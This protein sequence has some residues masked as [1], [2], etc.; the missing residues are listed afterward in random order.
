[1]TRNRRHFTPGWFLALLLFLS[2]FS[3]AV[4]ASDSRPNS[5]DGGKVESIGAFTAA[6]ASDALKKALEPKGYRVSAADGTV[7]CDIWLRNGVAGGKNDAL[8]VAYKWVGD[9]ALVAVI[10]IPKSTTDFRRQPLKAGTYTLRYALHPQDGNH[11]G[12]SP[13]RDF[14]LLTPVADDQD[15]DAKISFEDLNKM[16]KKASGTNHAAPMSLVSTD[17]IT[18]WPSVFE[19]ENGH[20]VFA[21]KIKTASGSESSIAF[22]V[23]GVVE[24]P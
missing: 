17:G 1:M 9:S 7:L 8:G 6:G 24:Q 19:D 23:K 5:P 14:L 21:A 4:C 15:P 20:L 10:T 2:T 3:F 11:L 16:S 22:V 12:I 18:A 13:I